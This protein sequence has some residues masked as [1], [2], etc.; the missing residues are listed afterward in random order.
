MK[1]AFFLLLFFPAVSFALDGTGSV[2][3]DSAIVPLLN[4]NTVLKDLVLCNFDIV[5]D[6]MGTRIGDVQSKALGGDRV[7]PYSMWANWHGNSGVKPVILTINT[8]TNFIDAHGKKVR[9]DLQKAVRIEEYVESVTIEPPDKDQP[10]S[11]PGGLKHSID[12]QACSVKTGQ[13]SK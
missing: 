5:G 12:A 7:G 8:R 11:V 10:Q 2:D 1:K 3:F 6:P 13:R 4:R 9:G